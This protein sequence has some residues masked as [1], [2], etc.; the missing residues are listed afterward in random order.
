MKRWL[1]D[2]EFLWLPA[3]IFAPCALIGIGQLVFGP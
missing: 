2:W 1:A 3:A